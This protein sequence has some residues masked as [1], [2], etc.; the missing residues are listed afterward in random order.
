MNFDQP[1]ASPS[2]LDTP[3]IMKVEGIQPGPRRVLLSCSSKPCVLKTLQPTPCKN[4]DFRPQRNLKSTI[5]LN[6]L[7]TLRKK[8]RERGPY[9]FNTIFIESGCGFDAS[10]T[11]SAASSS[12]NRCEIS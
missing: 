4:Q 3:F 7:K 12:P 9:G 5:N 2:P 8:C 11:A 6:R 1:A 10:L